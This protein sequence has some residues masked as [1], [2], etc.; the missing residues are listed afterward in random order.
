LIVEE[1]HL[2]KVATVFENQMSNL[3][4]AQIGIRKIQELLLDS[5]NA[6]NMGK[7]MTIHY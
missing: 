5:E 2:E 7:P 1:K 3:D 6:S 4:D